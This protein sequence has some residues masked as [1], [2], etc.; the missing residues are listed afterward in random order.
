MSEEIIEKRGGVISGSFD[1]REM[2]S[3]VFSCKLIKVK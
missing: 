3:M 1:G 2:V